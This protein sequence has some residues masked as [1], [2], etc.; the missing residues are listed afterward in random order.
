MK[1]ILKENNNLKAYFIWLVI[2]ITLAFS[3]LLIGIIGGYFE[4]I[5]TGI[6]CNENNCIWAVIPWYGLITLPTGF[7][8]GIIF[9]L[10]LIKDNFKILREEK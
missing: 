4:E 3:P 8:I 2:I 9:I 6:A 1:I 10:Y 7:L 5:K